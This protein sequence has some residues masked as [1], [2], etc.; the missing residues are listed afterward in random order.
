MY[1]PKDIKPGMTV[2]L[3]NGRTLLVTEDR[4]LVCDSSCGAKYATLRALHLDEYCGRL[5]HTVPS[6]DIMAVWD[7]NVGPLWQRNENPK[8]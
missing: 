2:V 7:P 1:T 3:R 6:Y 4:L 5:L 8:N